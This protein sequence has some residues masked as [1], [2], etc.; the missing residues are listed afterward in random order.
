MQV[1][2]SCLREPASPSELRRQM[3]TILAKGH[4]FTERYAWGVRGAEAPSPAGRSVDTYSQNALCVEVPPGSRRRLQTLRRL[5]LSTF[6]R[7]A[8][9]GKAA[10]G[11]ATIWTLLWTRFWVPTQERTPR[12]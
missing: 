10:T 5:V 3:I 8:G 2:E 6:P 9:K 12:M 4:L 11:L 7:R 1:S